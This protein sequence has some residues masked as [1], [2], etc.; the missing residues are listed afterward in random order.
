MKNAMKILGFEALYL[1]AAVIVAGLSAL[2]QM[3]GRTYAGDYSSFIFSGSNYS[4]NPILYTLGLVIFIGF[5]LAGYVFFLKKKITGLSEPG[6]LP[7]ILFPVIAAIFSLLIIA[8]VVVCEVLI[9]GM[10]DNM[11]PEAMFVLTN[12]GW[13]ILCFGF[14]IFAEVVAIKGK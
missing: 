9:L 14:M 1:L 10:N 13:A 6:L 7:R 5:M 11:R 4:Y 8:A 3:I 2:I 12:F